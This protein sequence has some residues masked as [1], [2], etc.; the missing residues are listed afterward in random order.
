MAVA[1]ET[2]IM[3]WLFLIQVNEKSTNGAKAYEPKKEPA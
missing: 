2:V 3:N 1:S